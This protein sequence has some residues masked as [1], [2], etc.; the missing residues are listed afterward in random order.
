MGQSNMSGQGIL[1]ELPAP[2]RTIDPAITVY[3]NDGVWRIA[4]EPLDD[5]TNQIDAVSADAAV[6]VGPGLSFARTLRQKRPDRRI[7]LVAC[8]K[9]GTSITRWARSL[10]RET[11]YGSCLA[12]AHEARA[13]GQFAGILWYQGESDTDTQA[14][15]DAWA[16]RFSDMMDVFRRD[17]GEPTLP[18]VVVGLGDQPMT[19]PYAG[20]FVA[21]DT[22]Q[23][24]QLNL[25]MN[26]QV[27]VSA[28]GLPRNADNLHLSTDGQIILGNRLAGA[29]SVAQRVR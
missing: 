13:Q 22:V 28:A 1:E 16:G 11:L 26:S 10:S 8:T 27:Y 29:M 7:G 9:G 6:G 12:R 25:R 24:D 15:A 3:G 21:W 5:A 23:K 17:L 2:S 4:S 14:D 20:R 19:G 18:L